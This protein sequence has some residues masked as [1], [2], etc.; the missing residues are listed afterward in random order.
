MLFRSESG[1]SH[2]R[3]CGGCGGAVQRG[4]DRGALIGGE[5]PGAA[6]KGGA[7]LSKAKLVGG[8]VIGY[9]FLPDTNL[10][11]A[12]YSKDTRWPSG[13]DPR[14]AGAILNSSE[15]QKGPVRCRF[16]G[17]NLEVGATRCPIC[18]GDARI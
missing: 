7:Y 16:C 18:A 6:G 17:A 15:S 1:R 11:G 3:K 4:R 12:K 13:F 9:G 14:R 8:F 2:Q 5:G 10:K